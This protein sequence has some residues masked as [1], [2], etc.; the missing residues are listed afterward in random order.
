MDNGWSRSAVV[1]V[2]H[3]PTKRVMEMYFF[4]CLFIF[5]VSSFIFC[6]NWSL[7]SNKVV[8]YTLHWFLASLTAWSYYIYGSFNVKHLFFIVFLSNIF[9]QSSRSEFLYQ[10]P[11]VSACVPY[12]PLLYFSM[13]YPVSTFF[14]F[15]T[16][17]IDLF[18]ST[19]YHYHMHKYFTGTE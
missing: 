3:L 17:T 16:A 1:Q 11:P 18:P 19:P 2:L 13:L 7:F 5:L 15:S 4:F 9:F 6:F 12:H 10:A 8:Q 14:K